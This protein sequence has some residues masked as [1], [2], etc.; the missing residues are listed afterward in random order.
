MANNPGLEKC[1]QLPTVT[2]L[3]ISSAAGLVDRILCDA[4]GGDGVG[5]HVTL[6]LDHVNVQGCQRRRR[7]SS[8]IQLLDIY[9]S[10]ISPGSRIAL[11]SEFDYSLR[12]ENR[13]VV[14]DTQP[15]TPQKNNKTVNK[16]GIKTTQLLSGRP[17]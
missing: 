17:T 8:I 4:L 11:P 15:E 6:N 14:H 10:D 7:R 12:T 13:D 3:E 9:S 5:I 16:I 1:I 2:V